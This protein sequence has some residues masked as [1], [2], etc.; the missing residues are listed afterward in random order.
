[1]VME[2]A[3]ALER[4]EIA[5][6]EPEGLDRL[7][8]GDTAEAAAVAGHL[9]GCPACTAELARIRRTAAIAREV[10]STAP[11]PALRARTLAYVQSAGVPRGAAAASPQA[12][13]P[14]APPVEA[15]PAAPVELAVARERRTMTRLRYAVV[16]L[17]AAL[18]IAIG[19]GVVIY[20]NATTT[21]AELAQ[22]SDEVAVLEET[23]RATLRVTAQP[24][25]QRVALAATPGAPAEAIG[26]L[27]FSPA[28][29]ELVAVASDLEPEADGQEYGCW[30]EVDGTRTRLGKM[31]W[32]GDLWTWAGPVNGLAELPAGSVFGVS[33]GPIGGGGD[34]TQVLAGSL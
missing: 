33:L 23:N 3:D 8:A 34:S 31:Y 27:L 20:R 18:V 2:H 7:M 17:A 26:T 32:A 16:A 1:M 29:G 19:S 14:D 13:V 25:A 24:D 9:A 30:V 6:A 5:A 11:D 15:P 4:I 28:T 21:Q 10:I 22:R 12:P